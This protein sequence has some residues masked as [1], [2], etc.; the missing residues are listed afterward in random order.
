MRI[1]EVEGR[2]EKINQNATKISKEMKNR[3]KG[4]DRGPSGDRMPHTVRV[5]EERSEERRGSI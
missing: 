2:F 3:K 4:Q 1:P 5:L